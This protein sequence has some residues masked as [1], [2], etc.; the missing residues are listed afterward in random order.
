MKTLALVTIAVTMLAARIAAQPHQIALIKNSPTTNAFDIS[1]IDNSTQRYYLADRTNN[2]IDLVDAATD[3]FLGFIG[4]GLYTGSRPCPAQPRDLRHCSGPNGV[5]TVGLGHVWAG[6]GDGNIIEADATKPGTTIIRKIP[7]GGKFR[8]DEL[9]YD[10]VHQILMASN[11]GDSPVFLTFVSVKDGRVL[12]QYKYPIDQDG[13]EQP[14][15]DHETGWFYQNVPGPKNRIDVFDPDKLPKPIQSFPVECKGGLLG[16][17]LSGLVAGPNARLM[18]VCGTVGGKSLDAR[19]GRILKTIPQVGDADEV[20]YDSGSN[21]YYFAHSTA[22]A[23][24]APSAR[25]GAI[26]VVDATT[27]AFVTDIPIEGAGVHSVAVNA[28]NKHIFVPVAGRGIL[29]VTLGQ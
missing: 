26:G 28:R 18:T 4:K 6:D 13:L 9:A 27:D 16:L 3:T 1:W 10:P 23:A 7:T 19:T 17:T 12:G 29:V 22:G 8:V 25:S 5:V 20:W 14:A 11:D 21:R 15:W 2:A 24:E